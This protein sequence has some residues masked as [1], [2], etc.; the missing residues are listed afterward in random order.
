MSVLYFKHSLVQY[1][2]L[3]LVNLSQPDWRGMAQM[4]CFLSVSCHSYVY[5]SLPF[6]ISGEDHWDLALVHKCLDLC[7]KKRTILFVLSLYM[8]LQIFVVK[9]QSMK[10]ED[11]F[12][13]T[14]GMMPWGVND[15][16]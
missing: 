1:E 9:L 15:I 5:S 6:V 11:F 13:T 4:C 8:I 16:I 10:P 3:Q 2:L 14:H 12:P 7:R